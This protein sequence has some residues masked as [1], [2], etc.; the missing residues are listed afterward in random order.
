MLEGKRERIARL[1]REGL[2]HYGEGRSAEAARAWNE[3]LYLDPAHAEARDYLATLGNEALPARRPPAPA[4]ARAGG[5]LAEDALRLMREGN[6]EAALELLEAASR[7][8]ASRMDLQGY[9]EM[10]KSRL[11]DRY[12]ERVGG[13][14]SVPKMH[15]RP[16]EVLRFNLPAT[17]GFL[18]SLVDGQTSIEDLVSLSGLDAFEALRVLAG[19]L[20]AGIIRSAA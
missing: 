18:L 19:L 16:D 13:L 14:R 4:A 11:H 20:D 12:R 5:D 15:M 17:A 10:L 3:V 2:D 9:L 6:L 8:D 1:L 7:R